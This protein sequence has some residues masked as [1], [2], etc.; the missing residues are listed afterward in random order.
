MDSRIFGKELTNLLGPDN[1]DKK[2]Y[3]Y[4]HQERLKDHSLNL[5]KP[6]PHKNHNQTLT[7]NDEHSSPPELDYSNPQLVPEY[8]MENLKFLRKQEN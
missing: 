2:S 8:L 1:R 6:H 5:T 3:S 7:L 4:I